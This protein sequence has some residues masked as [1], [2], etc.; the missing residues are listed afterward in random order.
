MKRKNKKIWCIILILSL[1]VGITQIPLNAFAETAKN[2]T[3][4]I[5]T[6]ASGATI[7]SSS[8]AMFGFNSQ[9]ILAG[10]G[11]AT[12]NSPGGSGALYLSSDG[13]KTWD[14]KLDKIHAVLGI[15]GLSDNKTA[16]IV[17]G[18]SASGV[19]TLIKKTVD[20]GQNWI[21]LEASF[22]KQVGDIWANISRFT[23]LYNVLAVEE[24]ITYVISN[25]ML[26]YSG[27]GGQNWIQLN[28]VEDTSTITKNGIVSNSLKRAGNLVYFASKNQFY[29][30]NLDT[31]NTPFVAY[32]APW[33]KTYTN[34]K[35]MAQS[36][37]SIDFADE[38]NGWALVE[39]RSDSKY[40]YI[41]YKTVD[42]GMHWKQLSGVTDYKFDDVEFPTSELYVVNNQQ[43]YA[44]CYGATGRIVSSNNG[45]V[46]WK[47]E[48]TNAERSIKTNY[49][50]FFKFGD[51]I[52][53][54]PLL[55]GQ[56]YPTQYALHKVTSTTAVPTQ[57]NTSTPVAKSGAE[58]FD[59]G[60]RIS[61]TPSAGLG[62]RIFRSTSSNDLGVSVTDF[63]LTGT[64]YADVN[65][66]PNTTYYYTVKSVLSEANPF[67]GTEE[68]LGNAIG[69]YT[70][71]TG[72]SVYK[73]GS[74]K[75]FIILQIDNPKLSKNGIA[76][77]IDPGKGTAPITIS[78]RTMIPISAVVE[79]IGGTI[80]WDG[81]AKKITLNARGNK[82]EMWLNKTDITVNGVSTK[83][84]VAPV[85]KNGRTFVPVKFAAENL[86][87]I[88]NWIN[89]TKEVVIVYEE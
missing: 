88:V 33:D 67:Q 25:N 17:G 81:T 16:Y 28:Y 9:N 84:D 65:V 43:L 47:Y 63:Y 11:R 18:Y 82:V 8:N 21:D 12:G 52:R 22:T 61:W 79:A 66:Q 42:G 62:Y 34:S 74:Y 59:S 35:W 3:G 23:L 1:V 68:Q 76:N 26:Y 40:A 38:L 58:A 83:M 6:P 71:T 70:I 48:E 15:S 46:T 2:W 89:S 75:N 24:N 32:D 51:E 27:D 14:K 19:G 45:G 73:A 50:R 39:D 20:G 80:Q 85:S 7:P 29:K 78:G 55:S 87:C 13:G 57:P 72:N 49:V 60:V 56:I 86:N 4:V 64:S 10:N 37:I 36:L 31:P 30:G 41:L 53:V 5:L 54:Y 77:E 44:F 69:S